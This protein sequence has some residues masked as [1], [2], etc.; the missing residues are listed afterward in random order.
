MIKCFKLCLTHNNCLIGVSYYYLLPPF[1]TGRKWTLKGNLD[2]HNLEFLSQ[3][4]ADP[5]SKGNAVGEPK[6]GASQREK[7]VSLLF[8]ART[9]EQGLLKVRLEPSTASSI[10]ELLVAIKGQH[11]PAQT[12]LVKCKLQNLRFTRN[13]ND[14][15]GPQLL[16]EAL[17]TSTRTLLEHLQGWGTQYL[18]RPHIPLQMQLKRGEGEINEGARE[19]G[20]K[21]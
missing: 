19:A 12:P 8:P 1:Y 9:V 11:S 13:S 20:C 17:K 14:H 10:T 15:P 2:R 7:P 16:T 3:V 5:I 21:G 6:P 4:S 18:Q